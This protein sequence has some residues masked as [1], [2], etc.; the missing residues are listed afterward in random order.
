MDFNKAAGDTFFNGTSVFTVTGGT[1]FL[2]SD[3]LEIKGF[4]KDDIVPPVWTNIT[5]KTSFATELGWCYFYYS[6]SF[7]YHFNTITDQLIMGILYGDM[8]NIDYLS[9]HYKPQIDLIPI[10]AINR[11]LFKLNFTTKHPFD[12][13]PTEIS[14]AFS[15]I[16]RIEMES[17]YSK[18]DSVIINNPKI[19]SV[20]SFQNYTVRMVLDTILLKDDFS[21]NYRIKAKD[22]GIIPETTISPDTGFYQCVWDFSVGVNEENYQIIEEFILNQNYPNPFNPGTIISW[23]LP[24]GS[25][26]TLKVFDVLGRELATL[27]DEYKEAGYH[28]VKFNSAGLASGIYYYQLKAGSYVETKKM[29]LLK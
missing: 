7:S 26:Q 20:D 9:D 17:F 14:S 19:A 23:Q 8:G 11:I 15:F 27:V 3:T 1:I 28:E 5:T 6:L 18:G 29:L 4:R 21:F 25:W 2:F 12:K 24:A 13:P 16:D 22:K 10:T